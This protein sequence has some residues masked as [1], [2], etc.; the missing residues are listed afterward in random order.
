MAA[1]ALVKISKRTK[2]LK[3][4]HKKLTHKQAQKRAVQDYRAGKLGRVKKKAA[5]KKSAP[6]KRKAGFSYKGGSV[7]IGRTKRKPARRRVGDA[8]IY[9]TPRRMTDVTHY[10]GGSVGSVRKI[11]THLKHQYKGQLADTLLKID[12]SKTAKA[13]RKLLKKKADIKRKLNNI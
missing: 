12:Q 9:D 2:Q 4:L 5:K 7:S 13:K 6:K 10:A 3:R 1:N 11:E 8:V